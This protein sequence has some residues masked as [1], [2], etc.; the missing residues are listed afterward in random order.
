MLAGYSCPT[1]SSASTG[2]APTS[3]AGFRQS[4]P[5]CGP[6][7]K[8]W[9]ERYIAMWHGCPAA[10]CYASGRFG[11]PLHRVQIRINRS[12]GHIQR[13][14]IRKLALLIP[15]SFFG[16]TT[17]PVQRESAP[18]RPRVGL[19]SGCCRVLHQGPNSRFRYGVR[20]IAR[21]ITCDIARVPS[22]KLKPRADVAQQTALN[23]SQ[24]VC[25]MQTALH[26]CGFQACE[27]P[28]A[29]AC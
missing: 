18:A 8:H 23:S 12:V 26:R 20:Q 25:A 19:S 11:H 13:L 15:G 2:R 7:S 24:A 9:S 16:Q 27:M 6:M 4:R 1:C 22:C 5:S 10:A 14:T 17:R 29:F 28:L 3:R 21:L